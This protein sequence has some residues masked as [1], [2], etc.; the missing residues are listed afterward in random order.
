[1]GNRG[2]SKGKGFDG[3]GLGLPDLG[4]KYSEG[5]MK[6]SANGYI[7]CLIFD[8]FRG[9]TISGLYFSGEWRGV[10]AGQT[11]VSDF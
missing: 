11:G 8:S 10:T 7:F 3:A 1:M 6:F 2:L 4:R 5:I 9:K